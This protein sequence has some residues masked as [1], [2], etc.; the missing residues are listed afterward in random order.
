MCFVRWDKRHSEGHG[1]GWGRGL[2]GKGG[3]FKS[4]FGDGLTKE[5]TAE[6]MVTQGGGQLCTTT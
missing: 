3:G 4:V 2:G 6:G 1:R 5:V